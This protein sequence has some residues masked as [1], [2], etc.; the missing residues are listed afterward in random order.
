[1]S[2]GEFKDSNPAAFFIYKG[3]LYVCS[4]ADNVKEFRSNT[5]ENTRKADDYWLPTGRA[6][7]QPYNRPR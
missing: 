3:K 7:G 5:D 6:E 2:K 1:M 4:S